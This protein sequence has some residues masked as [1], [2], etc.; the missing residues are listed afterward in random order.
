MIISIATLLSGGEGTGIGARAAGLKHLWGIEIDDEIAAAARENGFN[1]ITG[2]VTHIDPHTLEPPDILHASPECKR[3][4]SANLAKTEPQKREATEDVEVG[5]AIARF[6][7]ILNPRFFTLENVWYY[8]T[9]QAFEIVKDQLRQ[10]GYFYDF[11][12]LNSADFGVPQS[13]HRLIL[14]AHRTGLLPPVPAPEPWQGWYDSIADLLDDLED[15]DLANWQKSLLDVFPL[16]SAL[17]SQGISRDHDGN[18]Y[19]LLTRDG[20]EPA[21]T[22]TANSNMNGMRA[23]IVGGQYDRP[24]DRDG[25]MPQ[26]RESHA[27]SFTVTASYKGD[28]R[29][30]LVDPKNAGR[31]RITIRFDDN[32]SFAITNPASGRPRA[33]LETGRIVTLDNRCLARF[34]TFPDTYRLPDKRTVASRLIGNAVPPLMY[35]KLIEGLA[36]FMA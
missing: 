36:R 20:H 4:S 3:A 22:V 5:K 25:R 32:P 7:A 17:F 13:R 30:I 6:I 27:P 10:S 31:R 15:S 19:P 23:Y 29:A 11:E 34:Q 9:F 21:Y 8:R 26:M 16:K 1:V 28:W 18:Q 12:R 35:K 2:D 14:R 33:I 24:N